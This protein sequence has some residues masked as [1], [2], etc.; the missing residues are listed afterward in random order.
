MKFQ[1]DDGILRIEEKSLLRP[2]FGVFLIGLSTVIIYAGISLFVIVSDHVNA[3]ILITGLAILSHGIWLVAA[4]PTIVWTF[5]PKQKIAELRREITMLEKVYPTRVD[6]G[7]MTQ[8]QSD[9]QIAIL[10]QI[11]VDMG[12]GT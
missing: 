11:V 12:G 1:R 9:R 5:D 3:G 8:A 7:W 6:K 2:V 4:F 10:R